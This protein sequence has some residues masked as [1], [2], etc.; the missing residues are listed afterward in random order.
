[1]T[2]SI[3]VYFILFTS[4]L[5]VRAQTSSYNLSKLAA[6]NK[7]KVINREL[8]TANDSIS[9]VHLSSK[10]N[11]GVAWIDGLDFSNGIIEIDLKG[12]DIL[13]QSFIGIAFHGVDER[14]LDAVYFRPFNFQST[15]SVRNAH[16]VQYVSHPDFPWHIL[17]EKYPAQYERPVLPSPK[18]NAWFHVKIVVTYP[19]IK[20]FVNNKPEACLTVQQINKRTTGMLGLWVGNNSDGDF[21]NLAITNQ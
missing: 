15:D 7:I 10:E 20:V 3:A 6:Q 1:M 4:I 8:T 13:Q 9:S 11:D 17:R 5:N 2:K 16:A 14:T 18:P 19:Q 21:A 12:K